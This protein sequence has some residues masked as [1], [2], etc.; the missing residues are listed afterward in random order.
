LW[1]LAA[2]L[3]AVSVAASAFQ[4][5]KPSTRITATSTSCSVTTSERVVAI[6][7]VHG[8]Y[9]RFQAILRAA[10][11]IDAGRRWTGGRAIFVQTGDVLDR[12][13]DSRQVLDLL[14]RLEGEAARAGGRVHA[15]L[16]NHEVMR[17]MGDYR[18]VSEGEYAAFRSSR[19]EDLRDRFFEL[20]VD[21]Q[22]TKAAGTT[23]EEAAFRERLVKE[24]P[25]GFVEMQQAFGRNGDYGRWLRERDVMVIV[26]GLAFI[27]GGPS[28]SVAPLGCAQINARAKD[29]LGR[30]T[31]NDPAAST[32]LIAGAEGPLWYR[33]LAGDS[34]PT[35]QEVDSI[36][37]A[38]DIRAVVIGHTPNAD[39]RIGVRHDGR[40][41]TID[42][43]L[44]GGE[45]YPGG[46][47]SA[48]EFHNGA[49]TA[50]Y[51]DRRDP[52]GM[53]PGPQ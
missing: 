16:G 31:L 12:G 52:I 45:S 4:A 53:V 17:M 19:S 41:L 47:P 27:H 28:P 10:G 51:P 24:I 6:G 13:A 39:G 14:R 2:L 29:E 15:L 46:V 25:L 35:P 18:Y 30:L 26:N 48:I 44:L 32:S 37:S 11:L 9:E 42:T 50:I 34:A 49:V 5:S 21:D 33:G 36:F 43:G 7:D 22:K 8:G 20:L 40:V 1:V 23:F 3:S 38:L